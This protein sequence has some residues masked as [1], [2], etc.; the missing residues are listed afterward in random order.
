MSAIILVIVEIRTD[1]FK[2]ALSIGRFFTY[3]SCSFH[4][5]VAWDLENILLCKTFTTENCHFII[6]SNQSFIEKFLKNVSKIA[7]KNKKRHEK[8]LSSSTIQH[9]AY[10]IDANFLKIEGFG[11]LCNVVRFSGWS[12]NSIEIRSLLISDPI[13][14]TIKEINCRCR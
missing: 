12:N 4:K 9:T 13:L 1:W 5:V 14:P 6:I 10:S 8:V 7:S 2:K 11:C 3:Y